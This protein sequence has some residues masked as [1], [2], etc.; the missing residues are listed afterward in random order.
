MGSSP[1]ERL[2][3]AAGRDFRHL[4]EA[5]DETSRRLHERRVKI[6][7][8]SVQSDVSVVL[9]GSWGRAEVTSGSDDDY[10]ILVNG[11]WRPPSLPR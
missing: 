2:A 5:R 7:D 4:M 3:E 6:A 11:A 10:M 9:M 1:L 8:L